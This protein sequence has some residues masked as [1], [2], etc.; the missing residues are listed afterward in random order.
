MKNIINYY[1]ELLFEHIV[2]CHTKNDMEKY[3][4]EVW[5]M[6]QESYK[7]CGGI[8]GV[9]SVDDII[10]DSTLWK[11]TRRT[12]KI[13]AVIIYSNK[14]SGRKICCIAQDGSEQGKKDLK[15]MLK[16]DGMFVDRETWGEFSGAAASTALNQGMMQIPS[17]IAEIIMVGKKFIDK[18]EDGYFYTREI[19]GKQHIKIM[20]G[21]F[22]GQKFNAPENL[23][24]QLKELAIK[25]FKEDED[26]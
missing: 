18:K 20:L 12:D 5:N 4:D 17:D 25:Y 3:K 10:N 9:E 19:G 14:R 21:N 2:N 7:Y 22:K 16:E 8:A 23:I 6:L 13:T 15:K 1:N 24:K 11:L 26:K